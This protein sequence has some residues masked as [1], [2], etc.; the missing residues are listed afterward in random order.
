MWLHDINKD[1]KI[2]TRELRKIIEN[3]CCNLTDIQFKMLMHRYDPQHVKIINYKDFLIQLGLNVARY[4]YLMPTNIV[5]KALR[6]PETLPEEEMNKVKLEQLQ[7]KAAQEGRDDP[8]LQGLT[9]NE[10]KE[11]FKHKLKNKGYQLEQ[12]F[13]SFDHNNTGFISLDNFHGIINYIIMPISDGLFIQLLDN[14]DIVLATPRKLSW[15]DFLKNYCL[16]YKEL[17]RK[18]LEDKKNH[19]CL[20][21]HLENH[22]PNPEHLKSKFETDNKETQK[23]INTINRLVPFKSHTGSEFTIKEAEKYLT[24]A[25]QSKKNTFLRDFLALDYSDVGL[26]C[27]SDVKLLFDKHAFRMNNEQFEE[28]WK[29][30]PI[31]EFNKLKYRDFIEEYG[32]KENVSVKIPTQLHTLETQITERPH[33]AVSQCSIVTIDLYQEMKKSRVRPN[34]PFPVIKELINPL[35]VP[36]SPSL[37]KW[38]EQTKVITTNGIKCKNHIGMKLEQCQLA[39]HDKK[40]EENQIPENKVWPLSIEQSKLGKQI[41]ESLDKKPPVNLSHLST[42]INYF[43]QKRILWR[44][45]DILRKCKLIDSAHT[46]IISSEKF[47]E[48][49]DWAGIP[50]K[51][52]KISNELIKTCNIASNSQIDYWEFL[53]KFLFYIGSENTALTT[54]ELA[55]KRDLQQQINKVQKNSNSLK[56]SHIKLQQTLE[57][58]ITSKYNEIKKKCEIADTSNS[59]ILSGEKLKDIFKQMGIPVDNEECEKELASLGISTGINVNYSNFLAKYILH[60]GNK[61]SEDIFKRIKLSPT[62]IKISLDE[63]NPYLTKTL[64]AMHS[65]ITKNFHILSRQFSLSDKNMTG[66]I[67]CNTFRKFLHKINIILTEEQLFRILEY[68]DPNLTGKI[69]YAKFLRT[70]IRSA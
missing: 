3:Y 56:K 42:P 47:K 18:D 8:L 11:A 9:F 7:K 37:F 36:P 52:S 64:L 41:E 66:L 35:K 14:L 31:N 43:L 16:P 33:T 28:L 20:K 65:K 63:E 49:L 6:W 32:K 40:T 62:M 26:A 51:K 46:G 15:H 17:Y 34:T 44:Y 68:Y 53:R 25:V 59:G 22:V 24:E 1:G 30:F 5:E 2:Q 45:K 39:V 27:K 21:S 29:K 12:A 61:H 57:D 10:I 4:Q 48:I 23:W 67:D 38:P 54:A 70:F 19:Q 69:A 58:I 60:I 13:K 50:T 55:A